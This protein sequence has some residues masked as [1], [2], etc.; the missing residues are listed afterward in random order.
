MQL[1]N[2]PTSLQLISTLVQTG[3]VIGFIFYMTRKNASKIDALVG[4]YGKIA[5]DVAV[6]KRDIAHA[7]DLRNDVKSDHDRLIVLEGR[8][9]KARDDIHAQHAKIREL[10]AEIRSTH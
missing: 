4:A 1:E 10:K 9:D 5:T 3:V 2:I 8:A 6:L 7:L